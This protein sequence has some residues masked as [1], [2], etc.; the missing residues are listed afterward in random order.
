VIVIDA[1]LSSAILAAA[2]I[3]AN[4]LRMLRQRFR[5]PEAVRTLIYAGGSEAHALLTSLQAAGSTLRVVGLASPKARSRAEMVGGVPI[6][7]ASA[8][9]EKLLR[10]TAAEMVLLPSSL[11]GKTIREIS[12]VCRQQGVGCGMWCRGSMR[13]QGAAISCECVI[14]RSTICFV[15]TPIGWIWKVSRIRWRGESCW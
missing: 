9:I 13:F 1:I 15:A 8:G 2:R 14:S 5:N 6:L 7:D 12:D 10:R 3:S 4:S 11:P